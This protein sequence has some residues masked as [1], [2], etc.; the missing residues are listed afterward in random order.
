MDVRFPVVLCCAWWCFPLLA[1]G[2]NEL[3]QLV[4]A[5]ALFRRAN[6]H[7]YAIGQVQLLS[8]SGLLLVCLVLAHLVRFGECDHEGEL[9]FG[10]KAHHLFIELSGGVADVDK[11]NNQRIVAILVEV[12]VDHFR[13]AGLFAFCHFCI[14]I[15]RKVDKVDFLGGEKVDGAGFA[16]HGGNLSELLAVEKAIDEGRFPHVGATHKR[17]FGAYRLGDLRGSAIGSLEFN[18]VVV[19]AALLLRLLLLTN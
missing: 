4:K 3:A 8:D 17:D 2:F 19:N 15:S 10:E 16:W 14:A 11:R 7:V 18:Q 13:P 1:G 12:S 9:T 6:H 5:R